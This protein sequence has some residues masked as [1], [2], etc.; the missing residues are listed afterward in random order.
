[1][2]LSDSLPDSFLANRMGYVIPTN[3]VTAVLG[4]AVAGFAAYYYTYVERWPD[5]SHIPLLSEEISFSDHQKEYRQNAKAFLEKGY[6]QV[7]KQH[8]LLSGSGDANSLQ[9][10]K[11]GKPSWIETS[12]GP[13]VVLGIQQL[14]EVKNK[15]NAIVSNL[16][17]VFKVRPRSK[18]EQ[19]LDRCLHGIV[20]YGRVHSHRST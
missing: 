6:R 1:M 9:Y 20:C 12:E 15:P 11:N 5:L 17:P 8:S 7:N 18:C 10:N 2:G 3:T 13:K 14:H 19:Q 16:E 4:L